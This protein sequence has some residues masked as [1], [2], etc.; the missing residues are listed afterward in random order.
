MCWN[1]TDFITIDPFT[2][3]SKLFELHETMPI[4]E[5]E[6]SKK[7][8]IYLLAGDSVLIYSK[9]IPHGGIVFKLKVGAL[10]MH[11]MEE[12]QGRTLLPLC[13][14]KK[15]SFLIKHALKPVG[16]LLTISP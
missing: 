11:E 14:D 9:D 16:L 10:Q 6:V 8:M 12:I 5:V 13:G 1:E 15:E 4:T 3:E 7:A 2:K